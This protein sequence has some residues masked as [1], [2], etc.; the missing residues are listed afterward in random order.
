M[1]SG[2]PKS[3]GASLCTTAG[4]QLDYDERL[5]YVVK[6]FKV[7]TLP[8]IQSGL[9]VSY[10]ETYQQKPL[11]SSSGNRFF[12]NLGHYANM[13]RSALSAF[14]RVKQTLSSIAPVNRLQLSTSEGMC[15]V[16]SDVR[17]IG[18]VCTV[19]CSCKLLG[20]MIT[21]WF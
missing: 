14:F 18:R 1:I 9:M 16:D 4:P 19:F 12:L 10:V 8:G 15:S 3:L 7:H 6:S 11:H 13:S 5:V 17:G 2:R 20:I 21:I